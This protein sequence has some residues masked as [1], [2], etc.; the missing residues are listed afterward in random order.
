MWV[1]NVYT[2]G[3]TYGKHSN[4]TVNDIGLNI[5]KT[6]KRFFFSLSGG[7]GG[8]DESEVGSKQ[9]NV[10]GNNKQQHQRQQQ[11]HQPEE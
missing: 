1:C 7:Q 9:S 6:I 11:Q 3:N 4:Q 5:Q 8:E 2:N 10:N